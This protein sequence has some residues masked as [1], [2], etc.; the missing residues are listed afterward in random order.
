MK[1]KKASILSSTRIHANMANSHCPIATGHT[2]SALLNRRVSFDVTVRCDLTLTALH[3]AGVG[4]RPE[5]NRGLLFSA[6]S[7]VC[8]SLARE[9]MCMFTCAVWMCSCA[10]EQ[11]YVVSVAVWTGCRECAWPAVCFLPW[12]ARLPLL[13]SALPSLPHSA[14]K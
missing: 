6:Y 11:V 13:S 10:C 5:S 2:S 7:Y 4:G 9:G 1:D 3:Q 14:V 8:S 12:F